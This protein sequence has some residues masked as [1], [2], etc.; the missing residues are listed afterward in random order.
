VIE[1][2]EI[3]RRLQLG[4]PDRRIARDLGVSRHTVAHYRRW[5][6]RH[7]VFTGGRLPDPAA[8][9]ALL[10][11]APAERPAHEQSLVE[12]FRERVK[13]LHE[14]G[15]EGQARWQRLVEEHDCGGSYSS[16]KR[17]LRRLDPPEARAVPHPVPWTLM[18][19]EIVP[20]RG[21]P[22]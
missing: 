4:E 2:R 18:S 21:I 19:P 11:P 9:A 15:V 17:F 20:F 3:L 8:L 7:G 12:P 1:I 22:R 5:A 10:Q 13:A 6:Q 14:G 16:I